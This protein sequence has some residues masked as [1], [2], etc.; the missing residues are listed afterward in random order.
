MEIEA[1]DGPCGRVQAM[2][3]GEAVA[4]AVRV[5]LRELSPLCERLGVVKHNACIA[6]QGVHDTFLSVAPLRFAV[7]DLV[8]QDVAMGIR[9]AEKSGASE[10]GLLSPWAVVALFGADASW[11]IPRVLSDS[12]SSP[13]GSDKAPPDKREQGEAAQQSVLTWL[14][15]LEQPLQDAAET[16]EECHGVLAK[17]F[18]RAY[19]IL[20]PLGYKGR[21]VPV[22]KVRRPPQD[23]ALTPRQRHLLNTVEEN[24]QTLLG[25][26]C[27]PL[28][29]LQMAPRPAAQQIAAGF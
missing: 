6:L 22:G 3:H 29:D 20:H 4:Q 11:L 13:A 28:I 27:Q 14:N 25:H 12:V 23:D 9:H 2:Q 1:R 19:I 8:L 16:V 15:K 21:W 24:V 18:R 17:E 26:V 7:I 5:R 10:S